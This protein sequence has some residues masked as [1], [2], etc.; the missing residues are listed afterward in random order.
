MRFSPSSQVVEGACRRHWCEAQRGFFAII[1]R[2]KLGAQTHDSVAL[3]VKSGATDNHSQASC[4]S[5]IKCAAV[6]G[7]FKSVDTRQ[8]LIRQTQHSRS[9]YREGCRPAMV[10]SYARQSCSQY[11]P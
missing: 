6:S 9:G 2:L 3:I 10:Y 11:S 8:T 5:H 7:M 1:D 4:F